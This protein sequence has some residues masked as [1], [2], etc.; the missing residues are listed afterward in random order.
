[1]AHIL[2]DGAICISTCG[3]STDAR[4]FAENKNIEL[5]DSNDLL[6]LMKS[7]KLEGSLVVRKE[8]GKNKK[9]VKISCP[10]CGKGIDFE[11]EMRGGVG[12]KIKCPNCGRLIEGNTELKR[13]WICKYCS[14]KFNTKEET[15]KH[16]KNCPGEKIPVKAKKRLERKE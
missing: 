13:T 12:F 14:K 9:K 3:F 7:I 16:E 6:G 5:L 2:A 4:K 10:A 11:L 15:E 8:K 1:M